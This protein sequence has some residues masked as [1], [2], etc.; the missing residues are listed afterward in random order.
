MH[1]GIAK[2]EKYASFCCRKNTASTCAPRAKRARL[3][4]GS[5][6]EVVPLLLKLVHFRLWQKCET[7]GHLTGDGDLIGCFHPER[8]TILNLNFES[9]AHRLVILMYLSY[10]Q[11]CS[12]MINRDY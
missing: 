7:R 5:S 3:S 1:Y 9:E 6:F 2:S 8:S 10:D 12:I 4:L 11:L